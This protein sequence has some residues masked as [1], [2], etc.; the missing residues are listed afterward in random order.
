M[1]L[2][3]E[4][5]RPVQPPPAPADLERV[6]VIKHGALGDFIQALAPAKVIREH[7]VGARVTLLTTEPFQKFA[8]ACPFFDVVEIDSRS[9][10]PTALA[11]LIAKIRSAKFQMVYDL[12]TSN[13]TG[14]YYTL[15][16]PK[17][18]LW[19]GVASGCSHPHLNP[20]RE[21]MH[22]LD[23][24][25]DQLWW[26]GLGPKAGYAP[27]EAP[28]P[29]LSW[30]RMALRDPPRLKAEFFGIRP[31]YVL[32]VPGASP[33]R[34]EKRW[35]EER[36]AQLAKQIAD[37]GVT[38]VVLGAAAERE[39][40]AAVAKAEPRAKVL[41]GRTDLFQIATLAEG[42]AAAV[43]NDTGPMHIAA[44]SG[45]RCVVLFASSASDPEK[46]APRGPGG[47]ITL[48][49]HDLNDLPV[50]DVERSLGN[51]GAFALARA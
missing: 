32:M 48:L 16:R 4:M 36:Y 44:A 9:K 43:G 10:E 7:H 30:I 28:P 33:H 11:A 8:E 42:C 35:P 12:Q 25:A 45:A 50:S 21:A 5:S 6:L 19:S 14:N 31:P 18:P 51:V 1:T 41:V 37:R 46:V 49:A 34:P 26:A 24:Q 13:R 2:E 39:V 17:A 22:T 47:V 3:V 40:G 27:G 29:D 15:L 38:P 23:R 20:E